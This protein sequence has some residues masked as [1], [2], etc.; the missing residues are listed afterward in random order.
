[1]FGRGKETI[2]A[3]K[4]ILMIEVNAEGLLHYG[5]SA[6]SLFRSIKRFG[7]KTYEV[8]SSGLRLCEGLPAKRGYYN[9]FC[10]PEVHQMGRYR[11]LV[12]PMHGT[13]P[14]RSRNGD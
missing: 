10:F 4:P 1:M 11:Q 14:V 12:S 2:G 3:L 9:L 5:C 13:V 6:Y 8:K 7:Y